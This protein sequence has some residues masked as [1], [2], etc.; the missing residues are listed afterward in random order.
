MHYLYFKVPTSCIATTTIIIFKNRF[1]HHQA[2]CC[3]GLTGI[4]CLYI[5]VLKKFALLCVCLNEY[6]HKRTNFLRLCCLR[7]LPLLLK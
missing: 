5:N 6:M 1:H 7:L 3:D 4:M 2:V